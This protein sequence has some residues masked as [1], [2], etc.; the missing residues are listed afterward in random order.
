MKF[1]SPLK[2]DTVGRKIMWPTILYLI[3]L[4]GILGAVLIQNTAKN[5][6]EVGNSKGEAMANFLEKIGNIYIN[7]FDIA[8]LESFQGDSRVISATWAWVRFC[9][10]RVARRKLP[11]ADCAVSSRRAAV[12]F[13]AFLGA[14]GFFPDWR[15]ALARLRLLVVDDRSSKT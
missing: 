11:T 4:F 1:R 8:A 13:A 3:L 14:R 9:A 10:V 12:F 15:S 6:A 7:Y 2:L 5:I